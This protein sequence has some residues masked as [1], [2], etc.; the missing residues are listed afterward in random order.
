M[1]VII[2]IF[3]ALV[4]HGDR[5]PSP[6]LYSHAVKNLKEI[7]NDLKNRHPSSFNSPTLHMNELLLI[8]LGSS[9]MSAINRLSENDWLQP[10][11]AV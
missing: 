5:D 2:F 6:T 11:S 8:I 4:E 1:N 3:I 7:S 10:Y 9:T